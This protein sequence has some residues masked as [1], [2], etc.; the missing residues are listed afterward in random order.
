MARG[1][2]KGTTKW[3]QILEP[4]QVMK[5]ISNKERGRILE[6]LSSLEKPSRIVTCFK[7]E[8]TC[9]RYTIINTICLVNE[10]K[11]K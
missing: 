2:A 11:T 7:I 4:P 8:A 1:M 3:N 6:R 5:S 9:I 10:C